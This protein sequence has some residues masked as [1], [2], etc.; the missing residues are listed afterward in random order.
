MVA[1]V[2]PLGRDA[3][4][5][6]ARPGIGAGAAP[7]VAR[8]A[9]QRRAPAGE[10]ASTRHGIGPRPPVVEIDVG[11]HDVAIGTPPQVQ[12][13]VDASVAPKLPQARGGSQRKLIGAPCPRPAAAGHP[14]KSGPWSRGPQPGL[15]IAGPPCGHDGYAVARAEEPAREVRALALGAA[16]DRAQV[17]DH[18]GNV[19]TRCP[20]P[21]NARLPSDRGTA[22]A[23]ARDT[24]MQFVNSQGVTPKCRAPIRPRHR[25]TSSRKE[26]GPAIRK[27]ANGPVCC[28]TSS[29]LR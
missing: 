4:V 29:P 12:R 2:G 14:V 16:L 24:V 8:D 1:R 10:L 13:Y 15:Q 21:A 17:L 26:P 19:H 9:D 3:S 7:R 18:D 6:R 23:P 25:Y 27:E 5:A 22:G 28:A 11:Q 20:L